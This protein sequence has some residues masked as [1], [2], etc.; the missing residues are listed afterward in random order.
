MF[1]KKKVESLNINEVTR[2]KSETYSNR[3]MAIS[4]NGKAS[5]R[6]WMNEWRE[7]GGRK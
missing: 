4:F 2:A 6:E 3:K 7:R 5:E 1:R